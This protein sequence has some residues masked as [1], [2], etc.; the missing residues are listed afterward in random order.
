MN[1]SKPS[2]F[3]LCTTIITNGTL[4]LD[5]IHGK[6]DSALGSEASSLSCTKV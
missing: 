6:I 2:T 3:E 1:Y 5:K 4:E